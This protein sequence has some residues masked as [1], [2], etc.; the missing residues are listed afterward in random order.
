VSQC[1]PMSP[2]KSNRGA[3][4]PLGLFRPALEEGIELLRSCLGGCGGKSRKFPS[5]LAALAAAKRVAGAGWEDLFQADVSNSA[6]PSELGLHGSD[7]LSGARP[8]ACPEGPVKW[9]V[10][11]SLARGHSAGHCQELIQGG[12]EAP[13]AG[14]GGGHM[15]CLAAG[16]A[17]AMVGLHSTAENF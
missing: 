5:Q 14:Q 2:E 12:H 4:G 9:S 8:N 1:H 7:G 15:A 13:Q 3:L 6:M 17:S 10:L 16:S 11:Q